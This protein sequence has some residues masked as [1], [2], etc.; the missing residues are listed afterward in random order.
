MCVGI[1][2]LFLYIEQIKA[3]VLLRMCTPEK[4]IYV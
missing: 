3:R 1:S 4:T 2:E